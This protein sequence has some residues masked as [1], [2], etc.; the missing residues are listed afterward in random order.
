ML[1]RNKDQRSSWW[2]HANASCL[3][4]NYTNTN[5]GR[6]S[7]ANSKYDLDFWVQN[8]ERT[9]Y[10]IWLNISDAVVLLCKTEL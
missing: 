6:H 8:T 1:T 9:H 10:E 5:S 4:T 3:P 7:D 2:T